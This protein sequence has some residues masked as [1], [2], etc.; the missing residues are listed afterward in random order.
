MKR[1]VAFLLLAVMLLASL[2]SCSVDME[3]MGSIIPMY[4]TSPQTNLD[5][6]RMIYDKDFMKVAGLLYSPLTEITDSGKIEYPMISGYKEKYNE[7][8]GEYYVSID[9]VTTRW[10]DGRYLTAD[11]VVYAWKRVLSPETASPAA[12][13]LYDVKNAKAVKA[14]LMTVDDLGVAAVDKDT[15]EVQFEKP[16][17][18]ELFFETIS[19]PALVPM[20]DDAIMKKEET[21]AT[22]VNDIATNGR[23]A[24]KAMDPAGEYRL[25]FSK[26]YLLSTE[27]E[28]G[29]NVYVKPQQ[30]VTNFT[31]SAADAV[32]ALNNGEIYY[33][34]SFTKETYTAN[35]KDITAEDS[36]ASYTYFFDCTNATLANAKV[37]KALSVAL[38]RTEIANIIGMGTSAATGFV[39]S[40]STGSTMKKSFRDEAGNVYANKA[41]TSAAQSLLNEAGVKSGSFAITYRSDREYDK[42]V[43]EYAKGVWESLG[44]SVSLK[45]LELDKYEAAL[46]AS[47]FDV[48]ALDYQS[49]TTNPYSTL[50]PFSPEFSGSVVPV[51][52]N[53]SG[54]TPH[55]TGYESENYTKLLN[56]ILELTDRK[57][58]NAKLIELEKLFAEECPATALVSYANTY[59]ASDELKGLENSPY[60]FTLFTD[61]KLKNYKE[62]NEAYLA[63][64]EELE[65]QE[66]ANK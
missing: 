16:I 14:G 1:V 2:C 42:L 51:D 18:L 55:V 31:T 5:P 32:T 61:A 27:A 12:A 66:E 58:R 65:A 7:E 33:V 48:I 41:D 28:D 22:N 26:Y 29:Y 52:V 37:R 34:G 39:P 15:V 6:T 59:L 30:L 10:N 13:L 35:E 23:F 11:Q 40:S 9:L 45:G 50:A 20:R 24:I 47:E 53:S 36:L 38:D 56:E 3:D 25:D 17:D 63:K 4:L 49:L 43:A 62:K 46:Y 64:L 60:G 57:S 19:S 54:I 21:W 44:F 8:R